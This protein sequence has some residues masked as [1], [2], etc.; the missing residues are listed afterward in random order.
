[1]KWRFA[2]FS[3]PIVVL[4]FQVIWG[5]TYTTTKTLDGNYFSLGKVQ[6]KDGKLIDVSHSLRVVDGRFYAVTRN[7]DAIMETSG[8]VE[9]R[10]PDHYRLRVEK[11]E[12]RSLGGLPSDELAFDLLYAQNEGS[13]I[14][15]ARMETCLYG[16]E[17]RQVYCP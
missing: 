1:M 10:I 11:G 14:H 3:L 15:L 4:A 9:H 17:T 6:L 13:V 16:Q 2:L 12:V 8:V 7:G 5:L